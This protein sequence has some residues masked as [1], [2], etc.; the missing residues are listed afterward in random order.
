[1]PRLRFFNEKQLY[2]RLKRKPYSLTEVYILSPELA[3]VVGQQEATIPQ[4]TKQI[5]N[6][7]LQNNL[8]GQTKSTFVPDQYLA[9]IFGTSE[10]KVFAIS[11]Y[12]MS[13]LY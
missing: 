1:M 2:S 4:C 6:Y 5:W 10:T 9:K 7:I 13:H 12:I 8:K 3:Y 11:K